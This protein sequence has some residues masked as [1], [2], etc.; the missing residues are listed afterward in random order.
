MTD[1]HLNFFFSPSPHFTLGLNRTSLYIT[2]CY[3]SRWASSP[4]TGCQTAVGAV[5]FTAQH[6]AGVVVKTTPTNQDFKLEAKGPHLLLLHSILLWQISIQRLLEAK[7][8]SN[9]HRTRRLEEKQSL[10]ISSSGMLLMLLMNGPMNTQR[11]EVEKE[12]LEKKKENHF[13]DEEEDDPQS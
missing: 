13:C 7:F 9:I 10:L 3:V 5:D 11:A 2:R 4:L 1:F 8:L 6:A 12:D